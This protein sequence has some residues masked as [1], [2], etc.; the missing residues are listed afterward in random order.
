MRGN[1]AVTNT[2]QSILNA[3]N[4]PPYW[5]NLYIAN[6]SA[7]TVYIQWTAEPDALTTSNGFPIAAGTVQWIA[8]SEKAP[9]RQPIQLIAA[10]AG[11]YN[12]RYSL[13]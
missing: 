5:E 10:A 7:A 13:E 3:N 11:P 4:E 8:I 2:V 9:R 12:V 6:T 1:I